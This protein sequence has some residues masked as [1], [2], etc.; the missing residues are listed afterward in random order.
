MSHP[1]MEYHTMGVRLDS[2]GNVES[3]RLSKCTLLEHIRFCLRAAVLTKVGERVQY[4][5]LGSLYR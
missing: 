2:E 3:T 1:E 4:P 5:E